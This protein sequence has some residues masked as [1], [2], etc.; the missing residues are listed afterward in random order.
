MS[1]EKFGKLK[2]FAAGK[3]TPC[4]ILDLDVVKA[5]YEEL[6][7]IFPSRRYTTR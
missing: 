2:A 5:K 7:R 1:I 4:L 6:G 3:E